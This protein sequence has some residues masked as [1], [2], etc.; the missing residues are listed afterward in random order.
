MGVACLAICANGVLRRRNDQLDIRTLTMPDCRG[1]WYTI[2]SSVSDETAH[3]TGYLGKKVGQSVGV[4]DM[5]GCQAGRHKLRGHA[6]QCSP[7]PARSDHWLS[8]C[9][10]RS[11]AMAHAGKASKNPAQG[12]PSA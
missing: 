9:Q 4:P 10:A 5:L 6:A 3:R 1:G 11:E 12:G 2:I 8:G 7:Q